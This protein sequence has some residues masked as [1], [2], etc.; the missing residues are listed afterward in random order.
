MTRTLHFPTFSWRNPGSSGGASRIPRTPGIPGGFGRN[1]HQF[2]HQVTRTPRN[3]PGLPRNAS[4]LP[5][6][7]QDPQK[8]MRTPR[9]SPGLTKHKLHEEE[10]NPQSFHLA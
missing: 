10:L 1:E 8:F 6:M 4:G 7:H 3:A 9:N 2:N 5:G